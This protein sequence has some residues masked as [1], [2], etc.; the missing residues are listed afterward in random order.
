MLHFQI[1]PCLLLAAKKHCSPFP[2]HNC[3]D[4]QCLLQR[5]KCAKES[6]QASNELAVAQGYAGLW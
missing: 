5:I 3:S 6:A 2:E 4:S 1:S